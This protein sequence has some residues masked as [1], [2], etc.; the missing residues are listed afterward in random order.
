ML[1]DPNIVGTWAAIAAVIVACASFVVAFQQ[2]Q[3]AKA[4]LKL[5]LFEKRFKVF[6]TCMGILAGVHI[7][8]K[9]SYDSRL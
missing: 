5:D 8:G 2:Y 4:K 6:E 7:D 1:L 3:T 9:W